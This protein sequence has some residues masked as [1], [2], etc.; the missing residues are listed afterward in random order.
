MSEYA[1]PLTSCPPLEEVILA[2]GNELT[3][4][5]RRA[6]TEH[7]R[8]CEV[9]RASIGEV[10]GALTVVAIATARETATSL[11]F[12]LDA[13]AARKQRFMH[14]LD[15]ARRQHESRRSARWQWPV[16]AAIVLI[17]A[18]FM[19]RPQMVLSADGLKRDWMQ[20]VAHAVKWSFGSVDVAVDHHTPAGKRTPGSDRRP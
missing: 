15:E 12:S 2:L 11:D 14:R 13:A 19:L 6:L 20:R 16:A 8:H 18:G 5:E 17:V 3:T 7:L 4:P 10:E 9:C 1:I